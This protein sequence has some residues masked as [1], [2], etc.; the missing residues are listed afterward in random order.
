MAVVETKLMINGACNPD[1]I[2]GVNI[3]R[4]YLAKIQTLYDWKNSEVIGD[5]A[6]KATQTGKYYISDTTYLKIVM[7]KGSGTYSNYGF[8]FSLVTPNGSTLISGDSEDAYASMF[9]AKTSKG[10]AMGLYASNSPTG[11]PTNTKMFNVFIGDITTIDGQTAKGCIYVDDSGN[12]TIATDNGISTETALGTTIN[13]DRK[14]V[15]VPIANTTTG[16]IFSDIFVMRY[17][18]LQ[19]NIMDVDGQGVF[20]C[21][22]TVCLKD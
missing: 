22:K 19:Y 4:S 6:V 17:S 14:A 11:C 13:A 2:S 5:V 18:P 1:D 15:L 9:T 20:L 3:A 16:E 12:L 7:Q 21:G 10:L 8:V